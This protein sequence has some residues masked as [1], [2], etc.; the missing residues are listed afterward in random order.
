VS[1]LEGIT[2]GVVKK[3]NEVAAIVDRYASD[4]KAVMGRTIG[5]AVIDLD[6]ENVRIRETNLGNFFTDMMRKESGADVA[7]MNGG[8]LRAGIRRGEITVNDVYTIVPFNNYI[9]AIRLTGKQIR[10][11][12][13]YGVS[14]VELKEGRFPQVSGISC[15]YAPANKAGS[16][17]VT[18]AVNGM[19]LDH[20]KTYTVATNDFLAAG[21]DG[22]RVFQ[23]AIRQSADFSTTGGTLK[24][25]NIVYN[26]AGRW[27]RDI[28]V[29]YI[30]RQKKIAPVT[31]GRIKEVTCNEGIC[32]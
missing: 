17:I 13:E 27:L 21:G 18:V 5:E 29:G 2:P 6:G 20:E 1:S 22:Y 8:G 32:K 3:Q 12:L 28:A 15:T 9:V 10:D 4:V 31:E 16:R 25:S 30:T 11:T 23:E 19:P 24:S 7:I 26:D 14:A